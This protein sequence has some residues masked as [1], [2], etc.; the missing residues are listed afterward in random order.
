MQHMRKQVLFTVMAVCVLEREKIMEMIFQVL[1]GSSSTKKSKSKRK[2]AMSE[3]RKCLK[4]NPN[5][6]S[7]LL[8]SDVEM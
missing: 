6:R 5:Q 2:K 8:I 7:M 4:K 3:T 1:Q